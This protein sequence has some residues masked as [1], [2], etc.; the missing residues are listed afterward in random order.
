[1][2]VT[3]DCK[4][5][6]E[7]VSKRVVAAAFVVLRWFSCF[8]EL[9]MH[10]VV[11]CNKEKRSGVGFFFN[12]WKSIA[13]VQQTVSMEVRSAQKIPQYENLKKKRGKPSLNT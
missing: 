7:S 2:D 4:E 12:I 11:E 10:G 3:E 8:K 6:G 13:L 1:M 5:G 9:R